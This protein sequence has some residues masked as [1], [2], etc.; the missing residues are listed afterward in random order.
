[1]R[2]IDIF[3]VLP[4]VIATSKAFTPPMPFSSRN[5]LAPRFGTATKLEMIVA[6]APSSQDSTMRNAIN[7]MHIKD[8][9]DELASYGVDCS[10][11]F[12]KS[13]LIDALMKARHDDWLRK[14]FE[15][16]DS[17]AAAYDRYRTPTDKEYTW[18]DSEAEITPPMHDT[19]PVSNNEEKKF[20][21]KQGLED[22]AD[23]LKEKVRKERVKLEMAKLKDTKVQELRKE[24]E[25]YG[26]PTRGYF[27]KSEF[28]KAVAEARVDGVK[29]KSTSFSSTR[30]TETGDQWDSSFKDVTVFRFDSS[31]LD[32]YDIIDVQHR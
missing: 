16:N 12:E 2:D 30:N 18:N 31:L 10:S 4:F 29:K 9:R 8:I 7:S 13:E 6:S 22:M 32:P 23:I 25:S 28:T 1:M 17:T 14:E 26:I 21:F 5:A 3:L 15:V 27:E 11:I 19:D 24:L 20:T